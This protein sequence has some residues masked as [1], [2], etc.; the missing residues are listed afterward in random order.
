MIEITTT[1]KDTVEFIRK[2]KVNIQRSQTRIATRLTMRG[3]ELAMFYAPIWRGKLQNSIGVRIFPERHRGEVIMISANANY[4]ALQQEFNI[5][6]KRKLYKSKYPLIKEWAEKK[7]IFQDVPYVIVGQEPGTFMGK[8]KPDGN[9]F[10][11]PAYRDLQKEVDRIASVEI[12]KA[13][14]HTRA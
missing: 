6:G 1:V 8:D 9:K 5:L 3:K 12:A 7:G 11:L 10:F 4:I 13:I 14:M 2:S